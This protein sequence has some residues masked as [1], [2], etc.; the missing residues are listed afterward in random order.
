MRVPS[1]ET[2]T[3]LNAIG[4]TGSGTSLPSRRTR[5]NREPSVRTAGPSW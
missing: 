5:V 2:L 1:G 4:A 3:L